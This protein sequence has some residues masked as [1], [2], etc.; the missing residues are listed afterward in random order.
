MPWASVITDVCIG[1]VV[2]SFARWA[3][4]NLTMLAS[5]KKEE[6]PMWEMASQFM[7][8]GSALIETIWT[9]DASILSS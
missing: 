3:S 7:L 1:L 6:K 9:I 8:L 2:L 5:R 4:L